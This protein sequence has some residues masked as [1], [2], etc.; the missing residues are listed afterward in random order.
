MIFIPSAKAMEIKFSQPVLIGTIYINDGKVF[1]SKNEL[2]SSKE[3]KYYDFKSDKKIVRIYLEDIDKGFARFGVPSSKANS[4]KFDLV[5]SFDIYEITLFDGTPFAYIIRSYADNGIV[6]VAL[7]GMDKKLGFV[8]YVD[9][10]DF[11]QFFKSRQHVPL[12]NKCSISSNGNTLIFKCSAFLEDGNWEYLVG[13]N[14][15]N[16]WFDIKY[17][18]LVNYN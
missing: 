15:D 4:V 1:L 11:A 14:Q 8:K 17:R 3:N 9:N 2:P 7:I 10:S 16:E 12:G 13:W 6:H 5:G 18:A